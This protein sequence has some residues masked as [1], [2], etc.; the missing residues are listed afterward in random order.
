MGQ[1]VDVPA[2]VEAA[3][4]E[5]VSVTPDVW[6]QGVRDT[7][8]VLEDIVV[9][10]TYRDMARLASQYAEF[11]SND[12]GMTHREYWYLKYRTGDWP[13]A[14]MGKVLAFDATIESGSEGNQFVWPYM[15]TLT[16]GEITP[17]ARRDCVALLGEDGAQQFVRTGIWPG[18]R[19]GI[20]DDGT[21][22][23]FFSGTG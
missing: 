10:G 1:V 8:A 21:W 19:L 2:V 23:Y 17:K 16:P 5:P 20:R 4:V 7:V 3:P 14:H 6:S 22:V 12:G 15:A 13:M 9:N 18:Y 11:R